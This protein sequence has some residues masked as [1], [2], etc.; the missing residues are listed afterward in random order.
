MQDEYRYTLVSGERRRG[1]FRSGGTEGHRRRL[2]ARQRRGHR[3]AHGG[4]RRARPTGGSRTPGHDAADA[5][6]GLFQ[7]ARRGPWRTGRY[8]VQGSMYYADR[9]PTLNELHRGFAAG[10]L[11][12]N[13]NPL[14]E[15]ETSPASKAACSAQSRAFDGARRRSSTT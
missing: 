9:T 14:L 5:G 15:P 6:R 4:T 3:R 13:P 10:N 11:I 8:P 7:P 2:R 1:P 12:T